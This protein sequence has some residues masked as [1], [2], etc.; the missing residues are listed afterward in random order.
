M[1]R[2]GGEE[3]CLLLPDTG[4]EQARLVAERL[5]VATAQHPVSADDGS[6]LAHVTFSL[7]ITALTGPQSTEK[8]LGAADNALYRAKQ[9]G[10]NCYAV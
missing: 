3:F 8:L 6:P 2:Y 5:I 9:A 10:R 7:G 1:A 4:I